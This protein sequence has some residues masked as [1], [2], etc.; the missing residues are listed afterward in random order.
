MPHKD[1]IKKKEYM[2]QYQITHPDKRCRWKEPKNIEYMKEYRIKNK[3]RILQQMKNWCQENSFHRRINQKIYYFNKNKRKLLSMFRQANEIV[4][5]E[6]IQGLLLSDGYLRK[7]D[8]QQNSC[9]E[10]EQS[11]SHKDFILRIADHLKEIGIGYGFYEYL[12]KNNKTGFAPASW[13]IRIFSYRHLGFTK[14]RKK[15]YPCG[16]KIV[17]KDIKLT[18]KVLAYWFMGDGSTNWR[19]K[20]KRTS[21]TMLHT[22]GFDNEFVLFLKDKLH[23]L[24]IEIIHL[25]RK[26]NDRYALRIER[27]KDVKRLFNIIEPYILPCF[28]YKIKYPTSMGRKPYNI[29]GRYR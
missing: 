24:G 2:K 6:M 13:G 21:V 8:D 19:N 12:H 22:Q 23:E 9:L 3:E 5:D 29:I 27:A 18:P 16:K 20:E 11:E 10:V 7:I 17:P 14:L 28:N 4:N 1:P 15:W 25:Q 26:P